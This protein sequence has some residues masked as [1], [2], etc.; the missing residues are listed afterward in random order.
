MSKSDITRKSKLATLGF[1]VDRIISILNKLEFTEEDKRERLLGLCNDV[2]YFIRKNEPELFPSYIAHNLREIIEKFFNEAS[3]KNLRDGDH[4]FEFYQTSV[5]IKDVFE[6][7]DYAEVLSETKLKIKKLIEEDEFKKLLLVSC[8]PEWHEDVYRLNDKYGNKKTIWKA[9]G[10]EVFLEGFTKSYVVTD[11][12][13]KSMVS[14][15]NGLY[16]SLSG[17]AH[18]SRTLSKADLSEESSKSKDYLETCQ[19]V[20]EVFRPFEYQNTK[21][22]NKLKEIINEQN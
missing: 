19:G 20:Y 2:Q 21:T 3:T 1:T 13:R 9:L 17:Y 4:Q 11:E 12:E 5:N 14:N 10:S 7:V 16:K 8:E 18:G 22:I 6:S 15:R